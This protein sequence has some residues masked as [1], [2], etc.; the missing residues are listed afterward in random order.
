MSKFTVVAKTFELDENGNCITDTKDTTFSGKM[1]GICYQKDKYFGTSVTDPE[2]AEKRFHRVASTNHHTI[3]EHTYITVLCEDISKIL[4]MVLNSLNFYNTSEKSGRYTVMTGNSEKEQELY[5]KWK[6]I[7]RNKVLEYEPCYDD[8]ALRGMFNKEF[9]NREGKDKQPPY[10]KHGEFEKANNLPDWC[11]EVLD[12]MRNNETLPSM[13]LGQ[14]N[15][16]YLLSIFTRS[17][18]LAYTTALAQ[19]NYIYDWCH[20]FIEFNADNHSYFADEMKKDLIQLSDFIRDNIYVQE[21]RDSKGRNFE[22]LGRL[23]SD[24]YMDFD[25]FQ[26][27]ISM[28]YQMK[29]KTSFVSLAQHHRHRTIKYLMDFNP[30]A[31]QEYFVPEILNNDKGL[32]EEWLSDMKKV[33]GTI[34]QGTLVGVMEFGTVS[35]LI[36]KCK[37]RLCGRAQF[38]TMLGTLTTVENLTYAA[39]HG[40]IDPLTKKWIEK[41]IIKDEKHNSYEI[42]TKCKLIDGICKEPCYWGSSRAL[43]R[44]F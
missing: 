39:E 14:E 34:P 16:R 5:E 31:K 3:A 17:T 27:N 18:T 1:A 38:E 24:D 11:N 19:W 35:D 26:N 29:Y 2:L 41:L 20:K 28:A 43:D 7:F 32:K 44:P 21:L 13:K 42:K 8:S 23:T 22:F 25:S 15:A 33:S 12:D 4:A 37:E 6:T 40:K 9:E 10:I 36:L 30:D